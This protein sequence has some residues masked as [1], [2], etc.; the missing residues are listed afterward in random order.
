MKTAVVAPLLLLLHT[1]YSPFNWGDIIMFI[2]N[3]EARGSNVASFALIFQTSHTAYEFC[4]IFF[5]LKIIRYHCV[6]RYVSCSVTTVNPW[7]FLPPSLLAWWKYR[8]FIWKL[9]ERWDWERDTER[10]MI[11]R[12]EQFSSRK[13]HVF[14]VSHLFSF[15]TFVESIHNC[16]VHTHT[17][18]DTRTHAQIF[19]CH[20]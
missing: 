20:I 17:F 16:F 1:Y 12:R 18:T 4:W 15:I 19:V 2:R 9:E 5:S 10:N 6:T 11:T 13:I 3:L 14:T 8:V 7:P